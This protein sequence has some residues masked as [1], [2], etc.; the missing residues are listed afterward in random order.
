[1]G[2]KDFMFGLLMFMI[3]L[4][5]AIYY[6]DKNKKTVVP[7]AGKTFVALTQNNAATLLVNGASAM[8]QVTDTSGCAQNAQ[9]AEGTATVQ[10]GQYLNIGNDGTV[11]W[12]KNMQTLTITVITQTGTIG[13][14]VGTP[15][16][17]STLQFSSGKNILYQNGTTRFLESS[18]SISNIMYCDT[19][20]VFPQA[21]IIQKVVPSD[22][23][24]WIGS[25]QPGVTQGT[26]IQGT[27]CDITEPCQNYW[28]DGYYGYARVAGG[29]FSQPSGVT[30]G[31]WQPR[32]FQ[33]FIST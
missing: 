30:C 1:M 17:Y 12:S 18:S 20:V 21:T 22:S 25:S 2:R 9:D 4:V 16:V 24:V 6:H 31:G 7:A 8:I 11:S 10:N 3:C 23:S 5:I 33:I 29:W 19:V 26:V 14:A 13:G 28:I 15:P 27:V 32:T